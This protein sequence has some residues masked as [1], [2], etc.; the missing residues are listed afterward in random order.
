V[1]ADGSHSVRVTP[2]WK[3]VGSPAWSPRGRYIAFGRSTGSES[4]K[5][6]VA[7]ATGKIRWR[8][9]AGRYNGGALWSPDGREIEYFASWAHVYGL[10]VARMDGTGDTGI[11]SSPGFPTYG[12]NNPTWVPGGQRVAFD[13]GAVLDVSQ[14]IFTVALDGS[15]RR[16]LIEHALSPAFSPGGTKLA[17]LAIHYLPQQG[18]GEEGGLYI[19]DADGTN[20]QVLAP[21][22]GAWPTDL[23]WSTPAWSPDGTRLAFRRDTSLYGRVVHSDLVVVRAGGSGE[24]VIVSASTSGPAFSAPVWSPDGKYLAF[25]R[26]ATHAI[27]VARA[28][29]GGRPVVITRSGAGFAWRPAVA[30]PTT[31]RSSCSP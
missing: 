11:A 9:G 8:F 26:Y 3:G 5:V 12:P 15:D 27:V 1:R 30:L 28:D 14:G 2:R 31:K 6:F 4:S 10:R 21:Q 17:Y 16:M 24:R 25:E 20:P 19:A 29:G 7:T 22:T 13:D 23:S 18:V